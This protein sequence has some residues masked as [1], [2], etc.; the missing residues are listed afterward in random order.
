MTSWIAAESVAVAN[1]AGW[2]VAVDI[3]DRRR[4][5]I[6][7]VAARIL[8]GLAEMALAAAKDG[9]RNDPVSLCDALHVGARF[10]DVAHELMSD[11]IARFHRWY[12]APE[13][14]QIA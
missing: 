8:L 10:D 6:G 4:L 14:V 7:V 3:F 5:G 12:I 11:D 9:D 1:N 2:G 13:Q